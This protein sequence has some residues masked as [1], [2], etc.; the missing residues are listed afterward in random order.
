MKKK[1][2]LALLLVLAMLLSILAGCGSGQAEQTQETPA[3]TET[4]TETSDTPSTEPAQETQTQDAE[5]SAEA[6]PTEETPAEEIIPDVPEITYP[7]VD[8]PASFSLWYSFPGDLADTMTEWLPKNSVLAAVK[9]VTNIDLTFMLQS[10]T[11]ATE[12]FNLLVA[13]NEYPDLFYDCGSYYSGGMDK[14]IEDDVVVDLTDLV[15][16]NAPHY[17]SLISADEELLAA[18]STASGR[19]A[20]IHRLL[21][22]P[23]AA[24]TGLVVRKDWLDALGMETPTTLDEFHDMLLAFKNEMGATEAYGLAAG[25]V[26]DGNQFTSAFD[27]SGQY[28]DFMGQYPMYQVDGV[29][30]CGW[31]EDGFRDYLEL[32]HQWYDEGLIGSDFYIE[33]N[34]H[35]IDTSK[36]TNGQVGLW[37]HDYFQIELLQSMMA[38]PNAEIVAVADAVAYE[39]QTLHFGS[40]TSTL[41]GITWAITTDCWDPEIALRYIDYFFTEEGSQMCNYGVEGEGLTYDNN[42]DP[43]YSELVYNNP[44]GLSMRQ[45]QVMYTLTIGPFVE[46]ESR[47]DVAYN[48]VAIEAR[49]I[50]D[51]NS[52]DLYVLPSGVSLNTEQAQEFTS[53]IGDITT[54]VSGKTIE[55]IIGSDSLDNWDTYVQTMR[56]FGIDR[57]TELYQEAYDAVV[58]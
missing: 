23:A 8:T 42:G 5:A 56:D 16:T 27:V 4:A 25:G 7:L 11:T 57:V 17:Y 21:A 30:K 54:Y 18:T 50:W 20:E 29:V 15:E 10:V 9:D 3:A 49:Q 38:D 35:G 53:L 24:S 40:S 52:D 31:V 41:G 22:E 37:C 44:D 6:S 36:T 34:G 12:S 51:S 26:Q 45:T 2:A 58:Q 39:G 19:I 55:F 28:A 32:M 46:V 14:A 1:N 13:S 48:E 33:N 47:G 43:M